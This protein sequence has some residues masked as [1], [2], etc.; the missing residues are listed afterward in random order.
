MST[1]IA[2]TNRLISGNNAAVARAAGMV[3][4]VDGMVTARTQ[5]PGLFALSIILGALALLTFAKA[6]LLVF[7]GAEGYQ[8]ALNVMQGASL[9]DQAAAWMLSVD[10]ATAALA[11]LMG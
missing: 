7:M 11:D 1:M 5:R 3:M 10:V 9:A 6:T 4:T 8:S 2:Q